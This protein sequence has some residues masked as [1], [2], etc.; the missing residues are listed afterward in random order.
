MDELRSR[1]GRSREVDVPIGRSQTIQ[2]SRD[3]KRL[4]IISDS[5]DI[6]PDYRQ[7]MKSI[8]KSFVEKPFD[9]SLV[10]SFYQNQVY[11]LIIDQFYSLSFLNKVELLIDICLN[12]HL[13]PRVDFSKNELILRGDTSSCS[14]CLM[15][16]RNPRR[17]FDYSI[18]KRIDHTT[19]DIPLNM[20]VCMKI[21]EALGNQES[22]VIV[23]F[24]IRTIL[25][26]I[27]LDRLGLKMV[28]RMFS[29]SIY[30]ITRYRSMTIE[31]HTSFFKHN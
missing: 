23:F 14:Q 2:R 12:Y 26:Y 28:R 18:S 29:M 16:L 4:L 24:S 19:R 9:L 20:H 13:L 8:H 25:S 27:D 11:S 21:D 17:F 22:M 7:L 3:G 10:D 15:N 31:H 30:R 1:N 6:A 5:N